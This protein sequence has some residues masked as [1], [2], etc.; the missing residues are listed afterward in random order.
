M[1]K[2]LYICSDETCKSIRS[3]P[4]Q[5]VISTKERSPEPMQQASSPYLGRYLTSLRFVRYDGWIGEGVGVCKQIETNWR[6]NAILARLYG[7]RQPAIVT[8][9][10]APKT[11]RKN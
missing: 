5:V 9:S 10:K 6:S 4:N 3:H 11:T 1:K 8:K 7:I 2:L